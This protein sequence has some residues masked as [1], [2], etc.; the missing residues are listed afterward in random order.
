MRVV[1]T[2]NC[3]MRRFRVIMT[4]NVDKQHGKLVLFSPKREGKGE[5][6]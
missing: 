1:E 6:M 3:T 4:I 5:H 2:Q